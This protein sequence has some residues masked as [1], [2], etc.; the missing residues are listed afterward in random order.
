MKHLLIFR[1]VL[2]L[3]FAFRGILQDGRVLLKT[4]LCMRYDVVYQ[5]DANSRTPNLGLGLLAPP[6]LGCKMI[7]RAEKLRKEGKMGDLTTFVVAT[8]TTM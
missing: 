3:F 8:D 1:F 2:S 6:L 7:K 5:E 4:T